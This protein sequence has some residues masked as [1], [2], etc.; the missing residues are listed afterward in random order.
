MRYS[1]SF[2][3][4]LIFSGLKK[5][6]L[7]GII[8]YAWKKTADRNKRKKIKQYAKQSINSQEALEKIFQ[9]QTIDSKI[10]NSLEEH[11]DN[12]IKVKK[13]QKWP[14]VENPY[15]VEYGL[16]KSICRLLSIICILSKPEIVLETGVANGFSSSYILQALKQLNHGKLIS[17]DGIFLPWQTEKKIG[18]AIPQKLKKRH[19]LIIGKS[20]DELKTVFKKTE[21][22]DIFL[23]D[24]D[25]T[26]DNVINELNI[27]WPHIKNGG[28]LMSDDVG[29]NDAFIDFAERVKHTPIFLSKDYGG[30]FGIIQKN[31]NW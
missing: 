4:Q 27:V 26:Y 13:N 1:S 7:G 29:W 6:Q 12:F 19:I 15:L 20:S 23:R 16:T 22:V 31:K 2:Y 8:K 25:H 28:F 24:S 10:F 17:I 3:F 11:L 9:G 18:Q 30:F 5:R 21:Q 14:S